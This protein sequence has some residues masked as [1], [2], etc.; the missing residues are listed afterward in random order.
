LQILTSSAFWAVA[1]VVTL[2]ALRF[3]LRDRGVPL[4]LS[5]FKLIGLSIVNWVRGF[6][7]DMADYAED[8]SQEVRSRLR[9]QPEDEQ[10]KQQAPWR[11]VRLNSLSARDQI[12]YFYL[13]TVKRADERGVARQEGETPLEFADDLKET[14]PEAETE[15]DDLTEAFLRARYS[16]DVIKNEDLNPVKKQWKQVKKNLRKVRKKENK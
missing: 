3:F 14:W 16:Q 12:R 13:S 1:I 2:I 4:N 9:K 8:L 10:Q 7:H 11:F 5:L 15:I 6:W